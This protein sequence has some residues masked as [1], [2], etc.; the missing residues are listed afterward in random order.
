ML[1]EDGD[2]FDRWVCEKTM[3]DKFF[4]ADILKFQDSDGSLMLKPA[5]YCSNIV[6]FVSELMQQRG[7]D[8]GDVKLKIGLDRQGERPPED[9]SKLV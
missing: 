1:A 6:D 2:M 8:P 4:T 5:V 3:F 9:G 7:L